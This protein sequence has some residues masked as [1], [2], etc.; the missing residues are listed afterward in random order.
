MSHQFDP[1]IPADIHA[2]LAR[3]RR[4]IRRYVLLEGTALVLCILAVLFWVSLS[5]DY[6]YFQIRSLELPRWFRAAFSI[7]ALSLFVVTFLSWVLFRYLRSLREK[8]LALVL[9]RRFPQ[10]DDRLIT[11]VE[12]PESVTGRETPL[13]ASMLRRTVEDLSRLT[14]SLDIGA[15]FE[16]RP[17]RRA[18]ILAAV[19][20]ASI[21]GFAVANRD[22]MDRWVRGYVALE[23]IYWE[24]ESDLAVRVVV[25][26]GDQMK[27]FRD[28][29]YKHP[30]G[31]DLTFLVDVPETSRPDGGEWVVPE[32]VQLQYSLDGGRGSASVYMS[33]LGDRQF[34][35]TLPNQ[36]DGLRFWIRGHDY[37]NRRPY[38]V[39]A[40]PPPQIDN[41]V[42]DCDYPEYTGLNEM[43]LGERQVRGAQIALPVETAFNMR[44]KANKPLVGVRIEFGPLELS[45]GRRGGES[46]ATLAHRS[47]DGS[48]RTVALPPETARSLLS[49]EGD[50]FSVPFVMTA[51]V[52][53][54]AD[55]ADYLRGPRRG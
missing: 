37:V 43:D 52:P 5:L 39:I 22:A 19:L 42:L 4:R 36:L 3:L 51:G 14:Q 20:V 29:E 55:P 8:A 41:I 38:R 9:E 30:R 28:H 25:Q 21:A 50:R 23:D 48:R 12:L 7:G 16:K 40:V 49:A 6:A 15:V 44:A 27:E 11:A 26:P 31:G 54:S 35:H 46:E 1:R 33:R 24:R 32:R 10:L 47:D 17:L 53:E 13:T 45:F 34:R 2:L 18:V